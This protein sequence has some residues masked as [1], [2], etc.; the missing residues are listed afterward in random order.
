MFR[1]R[2]ALVEA[3]RAIASDLGP[4]CVKPHH[5]RPAGRLAFLVV[6]YLECGEGSFQLTGPE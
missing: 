5:D 3:A 4:S 2:S 1:A 6:Q